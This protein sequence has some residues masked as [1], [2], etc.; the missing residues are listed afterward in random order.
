MLR[1][2]LPLVAQRAVARQRQRA[3]GQL[4]RDRDHQRQGQDHLHN[5]FATDLPV[6]P[7]NVVQ[8]AACGRARWKTENETFSVLKTKGYNLE[9]SLS[10][11][12]QNLSA[13]LASLNLLAFALHTVCDIADEPWRNAPVKLGPRCNFFSTL[14]AIT[15]YL[16]FL[17]SQGLACHSLPSRPNPA[18]SPLTVAMPPVH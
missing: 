5:N 7:D 6:G 14:A 3:H 15:G 17:S 4:V 9:N 1:L 18:V 2:P 8:L 13:I 10:Y 12:K 16:V 11:G